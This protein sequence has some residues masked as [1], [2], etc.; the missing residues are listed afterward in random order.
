MISNASRH[1]GT[2]KRSKS[3]GK[4]AKGKAGR[5]RLRV[6]Q[7]RRGEGETVEFA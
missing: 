6:P 2:V 1:G 5:E 7:E 4:E 3:Q